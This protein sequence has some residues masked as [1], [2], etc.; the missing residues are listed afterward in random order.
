MVQIWRRYGAEIALRGFILTG[1]QAAD[2]TQAIP[3]VKD[4]ASTGAL[5]ADKGY[6]ANALLD[7]LGQRDIA[8]V[9]PPKVNRRV[10][11]S[12]DWY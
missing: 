3:L 2:I 7:W 8:A 1:G 10:Q 6:D 12:C 11:R 4:I 9:I 5:L